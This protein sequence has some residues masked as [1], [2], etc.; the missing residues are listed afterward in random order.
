MIY[1]D[2]HSCSYVARLGLRPYGFVSPIPH[3]SLRLQRIGQVFDGARK[4]RLLN[5]NC[6]RVT[7]DTGM[8]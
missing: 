7:C 6:D 8:A 4:Q 2:L 5:P 3:T 1:I